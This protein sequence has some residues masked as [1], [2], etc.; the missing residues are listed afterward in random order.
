MKLRYVFAGITGLLGLMV[1]LSVAT[2]EVEDARTTG[3]LQQAPSCVACHEDG[4]KRWASNRYWACTPYCMT[5]HREQMVRHHKIGIILPKAPE[6]GLRLAVGM[7]NACFTCHDLSRPRYDTVR[8]K[9][10]SLFDRLFRNEDRYKTYFLTQRN[11]H[12]QLCL[13]CH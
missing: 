3:C 12:G 9:A 2:P 13:S 10:T 7:R 6:N 1:T 11:D 4:E 5:C 8:W